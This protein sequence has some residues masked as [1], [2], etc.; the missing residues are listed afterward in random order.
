MNNNNLWFIDIIDYSKFTKTITAVNSKNYNWNLSN[1]SDFIKESENQEN[2][3]KKVTELQ[4]SIKYWENIDLDTSGK[5]VS[6]EN[7]VA[8]VFWLKNIQVWELVEFEN[9]EKGLVRN[10]DDLLIDIVILGKGEG[11]KEYIFCKKLDKFINPPT[12]FTRNDKKILKIKDEALYR[13]LENNKNMY[14]K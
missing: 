13:K 1:E 12:I 6:Y 14:R 2:D 11:L 7:G 9:N 3:I 8:K 10:I 4:Y 5:I